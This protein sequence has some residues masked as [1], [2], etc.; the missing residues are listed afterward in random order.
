MHVFNN[1]LRTSVPSTYNSIDKRCLFLYNKNR[2]TNIT[3]RIF[4]TLYSGDY[5]SQMKSEFDYSEML[6]L[7]NSSRCHLSELS[8]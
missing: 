8:N 2:M 3:S 4:A 6:C 5:D 7:P 1:M